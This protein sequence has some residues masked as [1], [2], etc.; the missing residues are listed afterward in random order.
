MPFRGQKNVVFFL[1]RSC[2]RSIE[3]VGPRNQWGENLTAR[4][5]VGDEGQRGTT[6]HGGLTIP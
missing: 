3:I 2:I 4:S 5:N 6:Q 1:Q